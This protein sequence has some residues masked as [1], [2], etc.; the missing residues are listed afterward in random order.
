MAKGNSI[1][2]I[3]A[4]KAKWPFFLLANLAILFVVG[5]STVRETYRGWTVDNEIQNLQDQA[6]Q[7][8]GHKLELSNLASAMQSSQYVELQ[9]REKLGMAKPGENVVILEG[10]AATATPWNL[11]QG[12]LHLSRTS[13]PDTE[14]NP[15]KWLRYF[16]Q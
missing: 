1:S 12:D 9:A 8:E 4:N 13:L 2:W 10:V 11:G 14:S 3:L 7:L 15:S 16:T 6:E 5:V